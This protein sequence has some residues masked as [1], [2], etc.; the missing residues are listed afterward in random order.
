MNNNRKKTRIL[1]VIFPSNY[2]NFAADSIFTFNRILFGSLLESDEKVEVIAVGPPD[3]P[4]LHPLIKIIPVN[5]GIS[6]FQVRLSFLW[7]EIRY[8]L[9]EIKPDVCLVN[10]PEQSANFAIIIKEELGLSCKLISYV[11]Y[12]PA[13]PIIDIKES[14]S[15]SPGI[16]YEKSMNQNG[17]CEILMMRLLEG[18][19]SSDITLTCSKFAVNLIQQVKN[20]LLSKSVDIGSCQVLSPPVDLKEVEQVSSQYIDQPFDFIYNHRLYD[21]YGTQHIFDLLTD[22][23]TSEIKSFNII[24]TNP[25]E[26]RDPERSRLNPAV[27][28]NLTTIK[29]LPFVK[30]K[31]F[32]N[33]NDYMMN[34]SKS[35]AGIA[36]LKPHALWSMSVMDLLACGK[37]VLSFNVA[38]FSEM[39]LKPYLLVKNNLDFKKRFLSFLSNKNFE[40]EQYYYKNIAQK[41]S[42]SLSAYKFMQLVN[43][44]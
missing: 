23:Y 15:V 35:R 1:T 21:D 5:L 8:L 34:L 2:P 11:H 7:N 14:V 6:K 12:I 27:D 40:Q 43:Q 39:G 22:L 29:S 9:N 13:M 41:Y 31:H 4:Q 18:V 28:K 3:M 38:A 17:L 30:V 44:L 26:G 24:V 37:P 32:N 33:R 19:I 20:K 10:M 16:A 25:T 36:P 42:G